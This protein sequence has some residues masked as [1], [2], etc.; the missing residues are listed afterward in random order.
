MASIP[1]IDKKL[2]TDCMTCVGVCP[3]EVFANIEGKAVVAKPEACIG[4]RACEAQC[5]QAAIIAEEE[6]E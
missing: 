6:K 4:C 2:C 1:R 3:M 5:P